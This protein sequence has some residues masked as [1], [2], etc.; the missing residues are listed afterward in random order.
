ME[1][2]NIVKKEVNE[3]KEFIFRD[4]EQTNGYQNLLTLEFLKQN[5][6]I[7]LDCNLLILLV[8]NEIISLYTWQRHFS[9]HINQLENRDDEDIIEF[10]EEFII[11][12]VLDTAIIKPD[13]ISDLIS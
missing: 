2:N 3:M 13:Q 5:K 4:A 9:D 8:D 1:I 10:V 6:K 12:G 7:A 11:K